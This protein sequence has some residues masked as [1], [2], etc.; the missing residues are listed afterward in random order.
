[1][2]KIRKYARTKHKQHSTNIKTKYKKRTTKKI[3]YKMKKTKKQICGG[4]KNDN[5]N[6]NAI[7]LAMPDPYVKTNIP[8]DIQYL[9]NIHRTNPDNMKH[10]DEMV[11]LLKQYGNNNPIIPTIKELVK[12]E[13]HR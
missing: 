2:D 4:N 1:M 13:T 7:L 5:T 11:Y 10:I 3:K 6:I 9:I 12:V 8:K